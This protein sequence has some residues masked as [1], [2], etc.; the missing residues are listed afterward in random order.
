MTTEREELI[1]IT[2]VWIKGLANPLEVLGSGEIMPSSRV[3]VI[4]TQLNNKP[5]LMTINMDYVWYFTDRVEKVIIK[6]D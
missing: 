1:H 3:L 4:S 2:T 6:S 5:T